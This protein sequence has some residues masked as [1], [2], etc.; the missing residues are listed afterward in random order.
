M[1]RTLR[2]GTV[3]TSLQSPKSE[4]SR[5]GQGSQWTEARVG[6]GGRRG[7]ITFFQELK[8]ERSRGL[9]VRVEIWRSR[10]Q[11][12]GGGGRPGDLDDQ[13]LQLTCITRASALDSG[14]HPRMS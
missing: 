1:Q 9:E 3:K 5:A 6:R 4:G 7:T 13:R 10:L 11:L 14:T 2:L 12:E 8:E